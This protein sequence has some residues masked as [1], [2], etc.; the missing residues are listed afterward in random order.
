M[1]PGAGGALSVVD[2]LAESDEVG[3]PTADPRSGELR[4]ITVDDLPANHVGL[5]LG[6]LATGPGGGTT[7]GEEG[8]EG[9]DQHHPGQP[10]GEHEVGPL[11]DSG[12]GHRN[13]FVQGSRLGRGDLGGRRSAGGDTG[14][15]WH[16]HRRG[17]VPLLRGGTRRCFGRGGCRLLLFLPHR[18]LLSRLRCAPGDGAPSRPGS[19]HVVNAHPGFGSPRR[20]RSHHDRF[21]HSQ[22]GGGRCAQV[23]HEPLPAVASAPSSGVSSSGAGSSSGSVSSSP[24]TV[25]TDSTR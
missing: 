9:D 21:R 8:E 6:G 12:R 10:P 13:H 18:R 17:N 14:R 16:S 7:Q 11:P 24:G 20:R 2:A 22:G 25:V 3:T 1:A 4:S 5:Q 23:A 15:S 19:E